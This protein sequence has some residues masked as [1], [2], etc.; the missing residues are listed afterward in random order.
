MIYFF[1]DNIYLCNY[2]DNN[3]FYAIRKNLDKLKLDL[4]SNF[5]ISQKWF[6]ENQMILKPVNCHYMLLGGHAQIDYTSLNGI[7]IESS[8]NETL[9]GVILDDDL[10]LDAHIKSLRRKA[11]QILSAL[12]RINTYLS[13]DQKLLLLEF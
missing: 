10:K 6:Y 5:L 12:S 3:T 11:A 8:R 1:I 4:Q 2:A 13:N 9:L 7:E